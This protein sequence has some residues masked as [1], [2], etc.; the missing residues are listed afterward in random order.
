[1]VAPQGATA[2]ATYTKIYGNDDDYVRLDMDGRRADDAE[3]FG[4]GGNDDLRV[5]YGSG[6]ATIHGGA[7]NDT[8]GGRAGEVLDNSSGSV[9]YGD[10]GNDSIEAATVRSDGVFADGGTGA[11]T[12]SGNNFDNDATLAGGE[13]DD[14][15]VVTYEVP[16]LL[17]TSLTIQEA[18]GAAGGHDRIDLVIEHDGLFRMDDNVEELVVTS[19]WWDNIGT[20]TYDVT[21]GTYEDAAGAGAGAVILGNAGAN[22]IVLSDRNDTAWGENGADTIEGGVGH[23]K[24]YGGTGGDL[25][26]GGRHNDTL[27]GE[28]GRDTLEGGSEADRLEGGNGHDL[29]A[30]GAGADTLL[31]GEGNDQLGGGSEADRLYGEG[32]DDL[33]RG[34]GGNDTMSGGAG[35]DVYVVTDAGDVVYEAANNG[36]DRIETTLLSISLA[37]NVE[38]LTVL[39]G[40]GPAAT[41]YATGNGL[42]NSIEMK[43]GLSA[44]MH[45]SVQG[46]GG[47][48]HM[49][50]GQGNDTGFG[51]TESDTVYG[52]DGNDL[53]RGDD[54]SDMLFGGSG[55][56][57]VEGGLGA[58]NL[59]GEA[60]NDQVTGGEGNDAVRG[61][62]GN[63]TVAGGAGADTVQGDDGNDMLYGSAGADR[64]WGGAGV[65][66]FN[67]TAVSDS[68]VATGR[69]FVMDFVKG[70]D[71][72]NLGF[73]DAD[74]TTA[75]NQDFYFAGADV[76]SVSPGNVWMKEVLTGTLIEGDVTGD[77][78]ADFSVLVYGVTGMTQ[79]DV[80]L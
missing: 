1:M 79:S 14:R 69:D 57:T 33:L 28:D 71:K 78:V 49:I 8:I 13:G 67:Y 75:G 48:D 26:R 51:G 80:I 45:D 58:D 31:G 56:D 73:M 39:G 4:G 12:L 66:W 16:S 59:R 72:V 38:N 46:V 40:S 23:D 63:D 44:L 9:L 43:D 3:L 65:D 21:N 64:L 35:N 34:E 70:E 15:Y 20:D 61:D 41:R 17:T 77:F 68:N 11:D 10:E 29:L 42:G 36:T 52:G 55:N 22:R 50:L 7:G 54:G 2:M 24:I 76:I 74:A 18:A 60:G 47:A 30:G 37:A 5:S 53:L 62:A 32:G 25:L 27:R 19:V 6:A